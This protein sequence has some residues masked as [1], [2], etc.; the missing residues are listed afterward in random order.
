MH[1]MPN[2][3]TIVQ[4]IVWHLEHQ[5]IC[6]YRPIPDKLIEEIK[7]RQFRN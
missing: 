7:K 5:K 6:S 2:N 1:R 3:L 4:R